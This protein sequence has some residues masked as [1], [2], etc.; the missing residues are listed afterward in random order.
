M[1]IRTNGSGDYI[2]RTTSLPAGDA[3][4]VAVWCKLAQIRSAYQYWGLENAA[5]NSS[6]YTLTGFSSGGTMEIVEDDSNNQFAS[7]PTANNWFF[8]AFTMGSGNGNFKGYWGYP[9]TATLVTIAANDNPMTAAALTIGNDSYDEWMDAAWAHVKVWDAVLTA[10]ELEAERWTIRP[11]RLANLHLWS[12]LWST[13]DINDY[14]GNGR[15]WTAGGTLVTE[16]GPPLS[17]GAAPWVVPFVSTGASGINGAASVTLD[18][19]TATA[20]GTVLTHGAGAATL[21]ALTSTAAGAVANNGSGAATL[22]ALTLTAAGGVGTTPITGAASITLA[23]LTST[24]TG[25]VLTHGAGAATLAALTSTAAGKVAISGAASAT[26]AAIS[27]SAKG[28]HLQGVTQAGVLTVDPT[29]SRYVRNASGIVLL[30]GPH[31]WYSVIDGG[32]SDPP[33]TF[34]WSTWDAAL[35]TRGATFERLWVGYDSPEDWPDELGTTFV[36][37]P[38]ERTGPGNAADGKPKFDLSRIWHV[39][40]ERVEERVIQAGNSGRYVSILLFQ[41]WQADLKGLSPGNP[42]ANHPYVSG[43]NINSINGNADAD[44]DVLETRDVSNSAILALQQGYVDAL[45]ARLNKYQHITWEISNEETRTAQTVAWEEHWV[46]YIKSAEAGMANQHLVVRS[47]QWPNGDNAD[48]Y[49][50]SADIVNIGGNNNAA[51]STPPTWPASG[52]SGK[53]GGMD[54]DHHGGLSPVAGWEWKS[55]CNGFGVLLLM[56]S[57]NGE[58]GDDWTANATIEQ[59]RYNLGRIADYAARMDLANATPQSSL[60]STGY[61][62]AKTSGRQQLIAYQPTSGNFTID[63]T[64]MAGTFSVEF[65]RTSNGATNTGTTVAGGAVR[66]L[67]APWAGEDFVAFLELSAISGAASVTLASITASAT[68][69]SGTTGAAAITLA[70]ITSTAT[71]TVAVR[72]SGAVTLAALTS[73]ATATVAITGSGAATLADISVTATAALAV[74]G[75]GAVTFDAITLTSTTSTNRTGSLAVTLDGITSTAAGTLVIAGSGAATLTGITSTATAVVAIAGSASGTLAAIALTSTGVSGATTTGQ[76]DATLD[77]MTATATGT[78][79][80][81]GAGAVSLDGLTTTAAGSVPV[82]GQAAIALDAVTL[83]AT[84]SAITFGSGAATLG[85]LTT[86]ATGLVGLIIAVVTGTVRGPS[87]S[88]TVRGV[89]GTGTVKG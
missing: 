35:V 1:A 84:T 82:V 76:L 40:L 58:F 50:S 2:R 83:F 73:T 29:N 89:K 26:L 19:L 20:T 33:P 67:T 44:S 28:W 75:S 87:A 85:D 14:S 10:A 23:G 53:V 13:S 37:L 36:P 9:T 17:W 22:D 49:A 71:A 11:Q 48:L 25:T 21:A 77:G 66:T 51:L 88:G 47:W 56:D 30:A 6:S 39:F 74:T 59:M 65:L 46:D 86:T 43:N 31:T 63:L 7:Q 61:C 80:I 8:W 70:A 62:L 27:V 18:A 78:V 52:A 60:A 79:A 16:D 54:T 57:W 55:F 4:T 41:G 24:A 64:G 42:V 45:L 5:S 72:G 3:I 38:Y 12:P 69:T 32:V 15:N 68:G 81:S 34:D